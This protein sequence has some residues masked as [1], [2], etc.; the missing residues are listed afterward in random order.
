[1]YKLINLLLNVL[2]KA[3]AKYIDDDEQLE[4]ILVDKIYQ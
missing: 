4:E 3:Y 2:I 1:M